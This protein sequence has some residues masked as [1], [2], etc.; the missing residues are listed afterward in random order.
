MLAVA[1]SFGALLFI[2]D[3]S[4]P[5]ELSRFGRVFIGV[6]CWTARAATI[7]SILKT[8]ALMAIITHTAWL[9]NYG[10]NMAA[11]STSWLA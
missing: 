2:S 3:I 1:I 10:T 4:K 7:L 11:P 6:C 8:A 5:P 9:K